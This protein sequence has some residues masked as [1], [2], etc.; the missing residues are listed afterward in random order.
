[1]PHVPGLS[2]PKVPAVSTHA[3][4]CREDGSMRHTDFGGGSL[5]C[6]T[7]VET[8]RLSPGHRPFTPVVEV[9]R[10]RD[11]PTGLSMVHRLR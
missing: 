9:G 4:V 11:T 6:P 2:P 10:R 1:M 5:I 3:M 8:F 7:T